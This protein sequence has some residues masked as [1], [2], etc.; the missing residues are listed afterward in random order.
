MSAFTI[1]LTNL[2]YKLMV[3]SYLDIDFKKKCDIK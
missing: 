3:L 2:T 1:Q